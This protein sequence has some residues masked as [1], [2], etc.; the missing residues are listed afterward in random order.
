VGSIYL[1]DVGFFLTT[2]LLM[3]LL[4]VRALVRR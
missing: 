1:S 3:L 4:A 2:T